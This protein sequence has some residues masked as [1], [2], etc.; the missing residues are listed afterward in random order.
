MEVV[1]AMK[2]KVWRCGSNSCG[3]GD[4]GGGEEGRP[5]AAAAA[6]AVRRISRATRRARDSGEDGGLLPDLSRWGVF[7]RGKEADRGV[8]TLSR[9]VPNVRLNQPVDCIPVVFPPG[10]N[11]GIPAGI[12]VS[13][14]SLIVVVLQL[15]TV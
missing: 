8:R 1:A 15:G 4:D 6:A 3:G 7:P 14:R 5:F 10:E 9:G 2:A 13:K 12:G 11:A